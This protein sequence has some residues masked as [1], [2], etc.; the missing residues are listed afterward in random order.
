MPAEIKLELSYEEF[1]VINKLEKESYKNRDIRLYKHCQALIAF[2]Y[3]KVKKIQVAKAHGV[4]THSINNWIKLYKEKGIEGLKLLPCGGSKAK[5]TDEQMQTLA[6]IIKDGPEE[7]GLDTAIWTSPIVREVVI[8]EFGVQYDVSHIRRILDKLKFSVQYPR[9]QLA[10]ADLK[11]QRNWL[12]KE[13]PAIKKS[14]KT[15]GNCNL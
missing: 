12:E 8:T 13:Y 4:T 14:P 6:Q 3:D 15:K 1:C 10:K 5:L 2:G 7:Y 11:K 9:V